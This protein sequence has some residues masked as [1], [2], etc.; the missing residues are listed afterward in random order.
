M[1]ISSFVRCNKKFN[2]KVGLAHFCLLVFLKFIIILLEDL[3]RLRNKLKFSPL[4][5]IED[6][7]SI[8]IGRAQKANLYIQF[9]LSHLTFIKAYSAHISEHT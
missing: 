2:S 4:F 5:G 3:L 7:G 1:K 9:K 6:I 8:I